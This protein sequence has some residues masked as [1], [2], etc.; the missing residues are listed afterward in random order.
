M[1]KVNPKSLLNSKW[2]KIEVE[3]REKHFVIIKVEQDEKQKVIDCIIQA[4]INHK[5]YSI[6]WRDLKNVSLWRQGW[7]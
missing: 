5:E 6:N 7:Q 4:V 3:D 2:T 1:N